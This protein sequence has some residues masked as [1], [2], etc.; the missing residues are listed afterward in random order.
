MAV[1]HGNETRRFNAARNKE[2]HMSFSRGAIVFALCASLIGCAADESTKQGAATGAAIGAGIGLLIGVLSGDSEVAARAVAVGAASGAT[3]GAYEGWRQGQDDRRT[4]EI[5]D[6]IRESSQQQQGS[7]DGDARQR[8]ELTRFLGV[9]N[10]TG[11]VEVEPGERIEVSAQLNGNPHM[12]YFV[13]LA[14][15]DFKAEGLDQ[16]IWGTTT[17][18]Y[19]GDTGFELSTRFNTL[20]DN[21]EVGGGTFDSS[22]RTFT[23]GDSD[24]QTTIRFETPDR[25]VVQTVD[26]N[27]QTVESYQVTRV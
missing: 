13:E 25:F 19:D 27:G 7:L 9:W 20:P 18:G 8:E 22:R 21:I 11:W 14:Y 1:T 10:L 16:Q 24:G 2:F 26:S 5:T 6:A 17:L 4:Q 12:N 15:I 23:F 3:R